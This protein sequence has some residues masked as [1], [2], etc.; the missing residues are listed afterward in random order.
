[1]AVASPEEYCREIEAYL[2]RKNDGHLVRIVGP[3]FEQV[4]GW[5]TRGVPLKVACGGIDRYFERYYAKGPRRR[6]V[7]IEFCE[8]DVLDAFDDWRRAVG[9]ATSEDTPAEGAEGDHD[10]EPARRQGSLPAHLER[11]IARLTVLR[12]GTDR[13]M[14]EALDRTIRELDAGRAK[15]RGLRGEAREAFL[16]RLRA[17]DGGLLAAARARCDAA[18]LAQIDAEAASELAPFRNR[19]SGEA[20]SEARRAAVER[21]VRERARLP[22]LAYD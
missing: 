13:E 3:A 19:L 21:L 10:E 2:C 22:I 14:D 15:A 4:I 20:F 6:P 1:V 17:L 16:D 5:A 11:V 7:R 12:S 18:T 8:A 9:I